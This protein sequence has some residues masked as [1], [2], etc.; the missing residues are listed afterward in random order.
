MK[1]VSLEIV[2][3]YLEQ[4]QLAAI[5]MVNMLEISFKCHETLEIDLEVAKRNLKEIN[6]HIDF[7]KGL[8]FEAIPKETHELLQSSPVKNTQQTFKPSRRE[9]FSE[10]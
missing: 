6:R 7:I 9:E 3:I 1:V 4:I 8:T 5:H 10:I 2:L